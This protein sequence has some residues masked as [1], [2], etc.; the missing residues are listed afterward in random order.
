MGLYMWVWAQAKW[1]QKGDEMKRI[2]ALF[3][4][5]LM[6]GVLMVGIS[7]ENAKA[8][9]AKVDASPG[10]V[11][12][13]ETVTFHITVQNTG[14]QSMEVTTVEIWFDWMQEGYF[15][16][17]SDVPT[18]IASGGEHT[19]DIQVPIPKG[20]PTDTHHPFKIKIWASDPSDLSEWGEAYSGQYTSSIYVNEYSPPPSDTGNND[21]EDSSGGSSPF[22]G[23]PLLILAVL[24]AMTM[25]WLRKRNKTS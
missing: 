6:F 21:N 18:V 15:Y 9:S 7:T 1:A 20:I 4:V 24:L 2:V 10:T 8:W 16:R 13:G 14:S 5:M 25:I 12:E 23:A 17:S 19:F 11:T 3:V 22:V